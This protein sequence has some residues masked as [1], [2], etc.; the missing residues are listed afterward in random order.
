M[1]RKGHVKK[2][3]SLS[4][5]RFGSVAVSKF[6]SSLMKGGKRSVAEKAFY[7]A[8]DIAGERLNAEPYEV[9]QKAMDNVKPLV[10]VRPRRVG[11]ATYQVPVEVPAER[12]EVLAI[13]WI[14]SFARSKKGMP[15]AERLAREL[16]DAYK[17]EGS[18]IKKREDTHKM[19]EA[20]RAF[21]HYRW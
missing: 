21:A 20:N 1:P 3:Q 18:S 4:D 5:S 11:G 12:A 7:G 6:I 10:E 16:M 19:A 15:I 17:G 8:L 13:R 9:F 14:V 2:R